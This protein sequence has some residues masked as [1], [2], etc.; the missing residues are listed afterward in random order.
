MNKAKDFY[1]EKLGLKLL[2]ENA[3]SAT[4][5]IAGDS[6]LVLKSVADSEYSGQE[7]KSVALALLTDNLEAWY[8]HVQK[9]NIHSNKTRKELMMDL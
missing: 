1:A 6:R 2:E 7:A 3:S 4:F 8:E 9:E 5:Q